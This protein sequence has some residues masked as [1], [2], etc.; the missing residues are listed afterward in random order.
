[1]KTS[2]EET[3]DIIAD[4]GFKQITIKYNI[5]KFSLSILHQISILF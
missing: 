5:R 2:S 3:L 1:M 4:P